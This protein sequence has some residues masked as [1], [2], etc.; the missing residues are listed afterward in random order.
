MKRAAAAL[1]VAL[2]GCSGQAITGAGEPIVVRGATF[3]PGPL[4]GSPPPDGGSP[5]NPDGGAQ[6]PTVTA[7]TSV[8]NLFFPGQAGASYGGDV[9]DDAT[10][11]AV[12]FADLGTGY[13]VF[14]PG[15]PDDTDPGNLTWSM[16]FEI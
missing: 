13:W 12:R 16:T 11:I 14:V 1:L 2:A 8:N 5:Q 15:P 7:I 6:S 4:P 10:A 3:V 9:T